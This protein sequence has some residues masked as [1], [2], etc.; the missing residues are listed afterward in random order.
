MQRF[1]RLIPY[2]RGQWR[3]L[4]TILLLTGL[5]AIAG[6]LLP[7]PMKLLVD[8]ALSASSLPA[9]IAWF[10]AQLAIEPTARVLVVTAA[11]ATIVLYLVNSSLFL[12]LGLSWARCG[13]R[14][15][16][17][18]ASDLFSHLAR[19]SPRFHQ[20][21]S[22]G[23][24]LSRL[25]EDT[26]SV[27]SVA[28]GVLIAP[29]Q[30][31]LTLALMFGVGLTLDPLLAGLSLA[32]SP[33][34]ALSSRY[35]GKRMKH[36]SKLG[37]EAKSRLMSFVHQTLVSIP[38]VQ[39]FGTEHRNRKT[40]QDL[41][42]DAVVST[43]RGNLMGGGYDLVNG[44][45]TSTGMALV[46]FV[47]GFRVLNGEIPLGTLLVFLAY[48]KQMQDASSGL[49]KIFTQLKT[50]EASV[51]RI[52]EV[53][54]SKDIVNEPTEPVPLAVS[55]TGKRGHLRFD[56]VCFGYDPQQPVLHHIQFEVFP[57]ETVALVGPSGAGKSTLASLI[58]RFSDPQSGQIFLDGVDIS[59]LRI[60]E[61]R[62]SIS[63]VLQEPYLL[64]LTIAENIAYG[65]PGASCEEIEA[66]AF[67]A[68]ADSFIRRLP[69]GYNTLIGERGANLSGGERQRLAIARAFLKDAPVLILDEPTSALDSTTEK[70]MMDAL[71]R[72]MAN[73]TTLVIAHRLSTI[74]GADRIIVLNGGRIEEIGSHQSLLEQ[75]GLYRSFHDQQLAERLSKA[76][77]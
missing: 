16:Y 47:G 23:D 9:P 68:K 1:R 13:L 36:R 26:W 52:L 77:A 57:G 46:L 28:D 25:T 51:D 69:E 54:D 20:R 75:Q 24:S 53:L 42:D 15:V 3:V 48:L 65:R 31:T 38:L 5:S 50:A 32:V 30:Q 70:L 39:T 61:L 73:R 58:P 22:L 11:I 66:A 67:A 27:Y 59:K 8:Q 17:D 37:R 55:E 14:M 35:F 63:L 76:I 72:L 56:N 19:L 4:V 74:R 34:L 43:Q 10:F 45:I 44:W 62:Q 6:A 21:Q 7:L 33:L 64:P 60:G 29:I 49:F 12:A 40:F 18:L 2:L 71:Q 41:A